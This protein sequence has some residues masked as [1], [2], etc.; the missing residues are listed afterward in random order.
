MTRS[1]LITSISAVS[2]CGSLLLSGCMVG[3]DYQRPVVDMPESYLEPAATDP[4]IANLPW[5]ELFND[6]NLVLLIREA[7]ANN[8]DLGIAVSRIDEAAANLGI[9][10]ANQFPFVDAQGSAGALHHRPGS[11][12]IGVAQQYCTNQVFRQVEDLCLAAIGKL[13][14]VVNGGGRQT[15]DPADAVAEGNDTALFT[16]A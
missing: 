7:L 4:S 1:R 9:V 6:P 3:P 13:Q 5:W 14:D 2:L 12:A 11:Q 16:Y 8:L 15:A 10:R